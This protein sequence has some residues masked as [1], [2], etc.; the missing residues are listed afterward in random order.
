MH[1]L[2][3]ESVSPSGLTL[4]SFC[5][6]SV[7]SASHI[8]LKR[9]RISTCNG[10]DGRFWFYRRPDI[11]LAQQTHRQ[12]CPLYCA[13]T[14]Y[15]FIYIP[16]PGR[17]QHRNIHRIRVCGSCQRNRRAFHN[18]LCL[19]ES[20]QGC[21]NNRNAA[22][23]RSTLPGAVRDT[24]HSVCSLTAL[25]RKL[26]CICTLRRMRT[27]RGLHNHTRITEKHPGRLFY[28]SPY[29]LLCHHARPVR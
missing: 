15:H 20:R 14:V 27:R 1:S 9:W 22:Y 28:R 21:R 10:H 29:I 8:A 12:Y 16:G 17:R 5:Y 19:C 11:L 24:A 26:V 4:F 23:L 25:Q 18:D 6:F 7:F 2:R 13:D 3:S